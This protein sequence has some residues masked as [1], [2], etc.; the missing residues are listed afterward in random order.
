MNWAD[1]AINAMLYPEVAAAYHADA[2]MQRA[3][4]RT[5]DRA[6]GWMSR[7]EQQVDEDFNRIVHRW[8]RVCRRWEGK[9]P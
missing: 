2:V 1:R 4:A 9:H 8:P 7:W 5:L 6:T 3:V